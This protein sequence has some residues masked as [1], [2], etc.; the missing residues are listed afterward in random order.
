MFEGTVVLLKHSNAYLEKD[1]LR[2]NISVLIM[3]EKGKY[4]QELD[5]YLC[6][7]HS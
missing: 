7:E 3:T 5:N 2:A 6:E 4:F 1:F